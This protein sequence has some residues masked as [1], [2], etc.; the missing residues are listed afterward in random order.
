MDKFIL[1]ERLRNIK[2]MHVRINKTKQSKRNGSCMSDFLTLPFSLVMGDL[3]ASSSSAGESVS[4]TLD[5]KDSLEIEK[6][7]EVLGKDFKKQMKE[8]CVKKKEKLEKLN[9][10]NINKK[11]INK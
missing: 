5:K 1:R 8:N 2:E 9:T 3:S 10:R 6:E 7:S 11:Q 4:L